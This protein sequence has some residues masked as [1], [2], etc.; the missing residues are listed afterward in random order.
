[1]QPMIFK[2]SLG[3]AKITRAYHDDIDII[4]TLW[5]EA[6]DWIA[7]K[8]IDQWRADSLHEETVKNQLAHSEVYI[9]KVED[10]V[11]GSLAIQWSDPFIWGDLD[12]DESGYVHRLVV[13]R[14]YRGHG[15]GRHLLDWAAQYIKQHGKRYIR[16]DCMA[17][18]P[19]L[20]EYYKGL[21]FVYIGRF[22]GNGWSANLYERPVD[23][24]K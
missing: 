8:G 10:Q 15:I 16:L 1:M 22:D 3:P 17:D 18:N 12:N 7:S 13:R 21:G 24:A 23:S 5:R 9:L 4:L 14:A 19:R 6:A 2:T 11:L 20:N